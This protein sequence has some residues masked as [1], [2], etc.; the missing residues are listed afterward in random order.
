[1]NALPVLDPALPVAPDVSPSQV[2]RSRPKIE[3]GLLPAELP[4][5]LHGFRMSNNRKLFRMDHELRIRLA[6]CLV[7]QHIWFE[8][9]VGLLCVRWVRC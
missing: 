9:E 2:Y 6:V 5:G 7:E 8:C 1:M 3:V 4:L